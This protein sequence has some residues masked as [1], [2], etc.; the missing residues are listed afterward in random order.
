MTEANFLNMIS[1]Y[2]SHTDLFLN[3][4]KGFGF[5]KMVSHRKCHC[6]RCT[7]YHNLIVMTR[8]NKTVKSCKPAHSVVDE[9][10]TSHSEEAT[11]T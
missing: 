2:G 9:R 5:V 1:K 8:R 11:A 10:F 7:I 4:K 6:I 3:A